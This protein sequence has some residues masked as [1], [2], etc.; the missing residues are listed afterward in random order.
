MKATC[1]NYVQNKGASNCGNKKPHILLF[2]KVVPISWH[3]KT[4]LKNKDKLK[5]EGWLDSDLETAC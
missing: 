1:A 3:V 5:L 2:S 4:E